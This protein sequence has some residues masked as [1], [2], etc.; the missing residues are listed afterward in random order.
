MT[1]TGDLH[2]LE[3]AGSNPACATL[4]LAVAGGS[5]LGSSPD[6]G[7]PGS[8]VPLL[9]SWVTKT[10][11]PRSGWE[12]SPFKAGKRARRRAGV[13]LGSRPPPYTSVAVCRSQWAARV[14]SNPTIRYTGIDPPGIAVN[15]DSGA[16]S[17]KA[18]ATPTTIQSTG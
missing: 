2:K 18:W 10:P 6:G 13:T 4:P 1:A 17:S 12:C 5:G 8:A 15:I 14:R 9:L 16:S 3:V 11:G 7:S